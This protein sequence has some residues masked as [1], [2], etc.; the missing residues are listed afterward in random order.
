MKKTRFLFS[1]LMAIVMMAMSPQKMWAIGG[2][3]TS[4]SPY[5]IEDAYDLWLFYNKVNGTEQGAY[6]KLTA[7]ITLT[8]AWTAMGTSSKPYTGTFDGQ[9]HTISGFSMEGYTKVNAG[10]FGYVNG[11]TIK[12]FTLNGTMTSSTQ[13]TSGEND[14]SGAVVGR[15]MG[16]STIQDIVSNV[17]ITLTK[18]QKHLGGVVGAIE[19]ST[20]VKGCTYT[21]TLNAGP[22]TDCIGGIVGFAPA[23]CSGS[24][25]YCFFNG[26]LSSS[27]STPTMGGILGYTN[28]ESNNFSGVHDCYSC[29]TLTYTGSNTYVNAIV[30]RI[31]NRATTTINNTYLSGKATRACNTDGPSIPASNKAITITLNAGSN[32]SV[33]QSYVNP[34][35]S[36]ATQLQVVATPNAHYHF[37]S[38]SDS[39]AQT[40]S[41][42][43]TANVSLSASFAIDQHTISVATNNT[44]SGTVSGGGTFDYGTTNV[45]IT[46]TPKAHYH[47]KQWNDGNTSTSRQIT[48]TEDKTYTATFAIDQHTITVQTNNGNYGTVSGGG[49][50]DYN[51]SKTITATPKTGYHFVEWNDG[52]TNASRTITVNGNATYT[53]TF[54]AH[55]YGN[56]IT[57]VAATCTT[58]GTKHRQCT[59][60][61]CDDRIDATIPAL[62]HD[63]AQE[64]SIDTEATCSSDGSKSRHCSRCEGTTEGTVIPATGHSFADDDLAQGVCTTCHHGFF[65]Y[66]SKDNVVV[67]PFYYPALTDAEGNQLTRISNTNVDG[68]GVIEFN[69]PLANIGTDAFYRQYDL[70]GM[71]IPNSVTGIGNAAFAGCTGFT[72]D[73]VIPTSV[74]SIGVSAFNGC[75]FTGDLVIQESVT[76]IGNNAFTGCGFTGNLVIPTSVTSIGNS[77][78]SYCSF[79]GNLVIPESVTSIGSFAFKECSG[80]TG[81]L[82]IP[83]SITSIDDNTFYGCT[84]FNGKLVIP[85]SVTHIGYYAFQDCSNF[86]SVEFNSIPQVWGL[87]FSGV[88]DNVTLTL[89]D[90]SYIYTGTNNLPTATSATFNREILADGGM[91]SFIVP[92][93]IPA[94]QAAELG[95]FYQYTSHDPE[96]RK[97]YFDDIAEVSDGVV[98]AN[99][100]YFFKP[101]RDITS[102]TVNNPSI[103]RTLTIRDPENPSVPGLYGTYSEIAVPQGAYGYAMLDGQSTF[104][105]AGYGNALWPFRAY[106]WLGSGAY[107][108]KALAFFGD[109]DD[110]T[111]INNIETDSDLDMS[112]PIYTLSGQRIMTPKKGEIY[113]QNGKKVIKK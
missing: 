103:P 55:T 92:F 57:D 102:F 53:A 43:L 79:S 71:T 109:Y 90:N 7:D 78:F 12:N 111:G 48:V 70:T 88:T 39:G 41:V 105:K 51:S 14:C 17:S 100:A 18:A 73:L 60:T 47:L 63:Y 46:A 19:G 65:R 101:A 4:S 93:D 75:G 106:L 42:G 35:T 96:E 5:T 94:S 83:T 44:N 72:G 1:L 86:S 33:S 58:S 80:F 91:Y 40:H 8:S 69:K 22:S 62:G 45:R 27:S 98:K 67:N 113:I 28:D 64:F 54:A 95:K 6:A 97:V 29:G 87:A 16:S 76:S 108:A 82:V 25:F 2:S 20:V 81:D 10:F 59:H 37:G 26:T 110:I 66:T 104:V 85:E 112:K 13:I 30:G 38:W 23:S 36:A 107:M 56:W 74:T 32:G 31:R 24:I 9:G 68:K 84:G 99:T 77:A 52:N 61:G 89:T 21:G 11:A 49:T 15:A 3:G 50:F 34:T